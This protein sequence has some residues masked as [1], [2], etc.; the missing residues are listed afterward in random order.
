MKPNVWQMGC[1]MGREIFVWRILIAS[2]ST[3]RDEETSIRSNS[4]LANDLEHHTSRSPSNDSK[5]NPSL[6]NIHVCPQMTKY[7]SIIPFCDAKILWVKDFG[8]WSNSK[9]RRFWSWVP[10]VWACTWPDLRW[11]LWWF[12]KFSCVYW[13]PFFDKILNST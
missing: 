1:K 11:L 10:N 7:L 3:Y 13:S 12:R 4:W 6:H 2:K 8:G 5:P 9:N